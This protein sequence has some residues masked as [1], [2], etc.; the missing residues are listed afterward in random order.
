M[1]TCVLN[2]AGPVTRGVE[3]VH[4]CL[5]VHSRVWINGHHPAARSH[6]AMDISGLLLPLGERE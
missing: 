5:R 4:Q 2:R 6:P 3:R 1:L